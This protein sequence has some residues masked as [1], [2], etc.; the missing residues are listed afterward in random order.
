MKRYFGN[1]K[2][3]ATISRSSKRTK[4]AKKNVRRSTPRAPMY[5]IPFP[6]T[7]RVK[8]L[9]KNTGNVTPGTVTGVQRFRLSDI[10]DFDY[11]NNFGNKQPLY[12]DALL[13]SSGPYKSFR[14]EGWT[15]SFKII[16]AT[17]VPVMIYYQNGTYKSIN[18]VDII[19]ELQNFPD[20]QSLML[21]GKGGSKGYGE[22]KATGTM[23]RVLGREPDDVN[24]GAWDTSPQAGLY[25]TIGYT[26]LDGASTTL[27][28]QMEVNVVF[29]VYLFNRD[30]T[31]S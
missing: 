3:S 31:V 21:T 18:E 6:V 8:L 11:D 1:V 14:V 23:K 22:I 30:A 12:Y 19:S 4:Y 5:R 2:D 9:Y 13:S 20:I 15:I 17:D 10:F 7:D 28:L 27:S 26:A 16:N 29:D 25:G 24:E